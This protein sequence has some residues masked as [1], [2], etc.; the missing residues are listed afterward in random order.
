MPET[1]LR[2]RTHQCSGKAA[3]TVAIAD[4]AILARLAA[5]V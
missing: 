4:F 5:R 1:A 2:Q 3:V